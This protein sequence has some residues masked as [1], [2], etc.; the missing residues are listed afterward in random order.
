MDLTEAE[1]LMRDKMDEHGLAPQWS[2]GW[3]RTVRFAGM[4]RW[5]RKLSNGRIVPLFKIELSKPIT[6][7]ADREHVIDTMHHEIAHALVGAGHSHDHVWQAKARE[8]GAVPNLHGPRTGYR[9]PP[10]KYVSR[11][12]CGL[13]YNRNRLPSERR[14]CA[15]CVKVHGFSDLSVLVWERRDNGM[16]AL[17]A[18]ISA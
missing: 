4:T 16:L 12:D 17:T 5:N 1:N 2:F 11:H 8:L 13:E 9:I 10:S 14:Y 6:E 18:N 7:L 3:S 15:K